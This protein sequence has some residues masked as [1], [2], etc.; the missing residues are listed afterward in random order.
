MVRAEKIVSDTI[1][2]FL[3]STFVSYTRPAT[4]KPFR[5]RF[6]RPIVASEEAE[7]TNT[8]P[9]ITT[10]RGELVGPLRYIKS[11][12]V[13]PPSYVPGATKMQIG[14]VGGPEIKMLLI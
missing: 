2:Q 1:L 14:D 5:V 9:V 6:W 11:L 13:N 10:G 8:F 12:R 7:L 3:I 4:V